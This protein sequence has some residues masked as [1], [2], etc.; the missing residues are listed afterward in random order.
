MNVSPINRRQSLPESARD[1]LDR[2]DAIGDGWAAV[3]DLM[4]P[5]PDLHVVNRERLCR[6]MEILA[7]EYRKASEELSAA[8]QSR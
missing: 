5:E 8:L 7:G 6:L 2:M 4:V 3:S 1:A